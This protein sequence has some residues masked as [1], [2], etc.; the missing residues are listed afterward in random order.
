MNNIDIAGTITY[1]AGV[2]QASL[3]AGFLYFAPINNMAIERNLRLLIALP[4]A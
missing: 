4:V 1:Q 3:N 2:T